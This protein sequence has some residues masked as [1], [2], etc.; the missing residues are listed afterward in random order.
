MLDG[1]CDVSNKPFSAAHNYK[2]QKNVQRQRSLVCRGDQKLFNE[3]LC[4]LRT[5]FKKFLEIDQRKQIVS[6]SLQ[7]SLKVAIYEIVFGALFGSKSVKLLTIKISSGA[8]LSWWNHPPYRWPR[9]RPGCRTGCLQPTALVPGTTCDN[10][11]NISWCLI[12]HDHNHGHH[13]HH[14]KWWV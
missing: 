4:F 9:H 3:L 13:I 7:I 2:I 5:L 11:H 14:C 6:D 12:I 1:L 10:H 8:L